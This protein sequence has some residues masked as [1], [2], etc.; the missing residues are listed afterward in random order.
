MKAEVYIAS[1]SKGR[2]IL[3]YVMQGNFPALWKSHEKNCPGKLSSSKS[4]TLVPP[5]QHHH[6]CHLHHHPGH[7]RVANVIHRMGRIHRT[8]FHW[9][10]KFQ[11]I[12]PRQGILENFFKHVGILLLYGS[13]ADYLLPA[14]CFAIE[15]E[16]DQ[17]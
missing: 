8:H 7:S 15:Q 9:T 5:S 2:T 17:R 3:L 11:G 4:A 13:N 16:F 6:L 12:I 1:P 14:S 10:G